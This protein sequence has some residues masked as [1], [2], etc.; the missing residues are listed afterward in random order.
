MNAHDVDSM[1]ELLHRALPPLEPA[2]P[3]CD[4]WPEVQRKLNAPAA[5][6][7]WFDWALAAALIAFVVVAP[8]SIPVL[9]YY[10]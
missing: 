4:L 5:A 10:L 2:A 7:P 8:S 9:L 1:I 3:E 6:P